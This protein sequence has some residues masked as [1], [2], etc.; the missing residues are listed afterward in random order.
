MVWLLKVL[1]TSS[2]ALR[3]SKLKRKSD[4]CQETEEARPRYSPSEANTTTIAVLVAQ[5]A[6]RRYLV[7]CKKLAELVLIHRLREVGDVEVRVA[8]VRKGL[9]LGVERF[10]LDYQYTGPDQMGKIATTTYPREADFVAQIVK[11]ADAILGVFVV[12]VLDEA[13]TVYRSGMN[14]SGGW[15]D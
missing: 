3:V 14:T 1:I 6:R 2:Q 13:K 8:L 4:K 15:I 5:D 9:E 10:L 11:A 12:V 7:R